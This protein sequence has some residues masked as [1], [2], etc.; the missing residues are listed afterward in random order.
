M[1]SITEAKNK[2]PMEFV[3]NLYTIFPTLTVDKIIT[4]MLCKR[5]TTIR[6]NTL[7][8]N[9]NT[10]KQLLQEEQKEKLDLKNIF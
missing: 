8:T 10:I 9:I 7:K 4:G 6:V 3:E 5:N 1:I 2:L